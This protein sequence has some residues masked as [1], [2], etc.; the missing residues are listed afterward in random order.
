MLYFDG[1]VFIVACC[2]MWATI[3][4]FKGIISGFPSFAPISGMIFMFFVPFVLAYAC[5]LKS[6]FWETKNG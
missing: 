5:K 3:G 1:K 2:V 4:L 6:N